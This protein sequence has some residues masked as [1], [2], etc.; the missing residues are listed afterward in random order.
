MTVARLVLL[1]AGVIIF[2]Y[3][4]NTGTTWARY[5]AIGL[6]AVALLT[7]LLERLMRSRRM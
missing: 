7:R 4:L 5:L 3:S 6:V 1:L 2:G